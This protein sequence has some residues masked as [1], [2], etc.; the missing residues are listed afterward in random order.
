MS[1]DFSP[2]VE[3]APHRRR[4]SFDPS[5]NL[6]HVL[7]FVGFMVSGFTAYNALDKRVTVME[8]HAASVV[9]RNREQDTR[10]KETLSEIKGDVKELQRS[11]NDVSRN[12]NSA[13]QVAPARK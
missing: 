8:S 5:I 7:T 11:V 2:L 9:E 3:Q 10:L 13:P 12:L 6:G 1:S 4:V